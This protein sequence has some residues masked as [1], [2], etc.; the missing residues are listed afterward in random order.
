[1]PNTIQRSVRAPCTSSRPEGGEP[2]RW[3]VAV[4][5]EFEVDAPDRERAVGRAE[6]LL[7]TAMPGERLRDGT[8][9]EIV[10]SLPVAAGGSR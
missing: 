2:T 4:E 5:L 3:R 8:R 10:M 6:E 9:V 7:R 1:M